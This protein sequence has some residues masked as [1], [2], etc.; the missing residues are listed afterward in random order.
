M[1]VAARERLAF[2]G[3]PF[4]LLSLSPLPF[5]S[6][7]LARARGFPLPILSAQPPRVLVLLARA[8]K[9]IGDSRYPL[10]AAVAAAA[11]VKARRRQRR[12]ECFFFAN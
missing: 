9:N 6:P 4:S 2:E 5:F 10:A 11:A 7:D 8:F 1:A 3:E 12:E